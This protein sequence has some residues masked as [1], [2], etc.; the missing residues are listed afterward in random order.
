MAVLRYASWY[1]RQSRRSFLYKVQG[2]FQV[3]CRVERDVDFGGVLK[4]TELHT[5]PRSER[6]QN[7]NGS[8]DA[9]RMLSQ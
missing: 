4:V 9:R 7:F 2:F 3:L 1:S 8:K 5:H 6:V